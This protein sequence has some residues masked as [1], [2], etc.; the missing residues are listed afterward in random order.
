D[1]ID[2]LFSPE[3]KINIYRI[4]QESLTNIVRHAEASRLEVKINQE[5]N[6][7]IFR[8]KDDGKGFD[9]KKVRSRSLRERGLGLTA[10]HERALMADG[11]LNIWSRKG[12]GTEITLTIPINK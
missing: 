2:H 8:L 9:L 12:Q 1:E 10:M 11:T 6:R 3:A 5:K 4:F 7:V